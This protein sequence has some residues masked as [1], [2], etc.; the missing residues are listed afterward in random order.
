[1]LQ[2]GGYCSLLVVCAYWGWIVC[3]FVL[4]IPYVLIALADKY[5]TKW[6][7]EAVGDHL[8]IWNNQSSTKPSPAAIW[9]N[10]DPQRSGRVFSWD[11]LGSKRT[12]MSGRRRGPRSD[13]CPQIFLWTRSCSSMT[14]WYKYSMDRQCASEFPLHNIL[15]DPTKV[16][17]S[18]LHWSVQERCLT[19][20]AVT[21]DF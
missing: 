8:A 21:G 10:G 19:V 5:R 18:L 14:K 1:M 12:E 16:E 9:Q 7:I 4:W 20:T 15:R 2:E 3:R 17:A 13:P 6:A 11:S